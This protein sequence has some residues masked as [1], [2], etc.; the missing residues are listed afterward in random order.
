MPM[1]WEIFF[2]AQSLSG[3]CYS[4]GQTYATCFVYQFVIGQFDS[5]DSKEF[6]SKKKADNLYMI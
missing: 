3:L 2:N 6:D 1:N 5:F 4:L